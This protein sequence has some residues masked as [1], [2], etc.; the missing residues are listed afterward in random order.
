MENW[1]R[2][3][4][5]RKVVHDDWWLGHELLGLLVEGWLLGEGMGV[6]GLSDRDRV[7]VIW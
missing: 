6:D 5:L 4:I 2:G 3:Q 1:L 7:V